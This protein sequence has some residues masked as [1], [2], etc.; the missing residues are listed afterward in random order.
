MQTKKEFV[1]FVL[2]LFIVSILST[3]FII[4]ENTSNIQKEIPQTISFLDRENNTSRWEREVS[5][6]RDPATGQI[7][8]GIR[9]LELKFART[10]PAYN[11]S[12][13]KKN[14]AG[15]VGLDWVSRGPINY[16]GR[17]RALA[18]DVTNENRIIAGGVSGGMWYSTDGG[19]S[20]SKAS[21][22]P[23]YQS[24]SCV[25][26]DTRPGHTNTWYY[27]SGE[28][29]GNTASGGVA[30]LGLGNQGF[31]SGDGIYKSTDSGVTWTQLPSTILDVTS[32]YS[33][34]LVF[35]LAIDPSRMDSTIIYA[36]CFR[37]IYRSNDGGTT[38]SRCNLL[39]TS[40]TDVAVSSKGIVY[41]ALSTNDVNVSNV[42]GIF[43]S[44][45]GLNWTNIS[46]VSFDSDN[47]GRIVI[48]LAPS[49]ENI[50]YFLQGAYFYDNEFLWKYT[51]PGN[52]YGA[53]Q[54]NWDDLSSNLPQNFFTQWSYDIVLKVKPDN[55]KNVIFGG[56]NLYRTT[57]GFATPVGDENWIGGYYHPPSHADMQALAFLPSN[58][59]TLLIGTDGGVYKTI[60]VTAPNVS[61]IVRNNGYI[62]TQFYSVALDHGISGDNTIYGGL[63]DL[64]FLLTHSG[65]PIQPWMEA[66]ADEGGGEGIFLAIA[67]SGSYYYQETFG[68]IDRLKPDNTATSFS[69]LTNITPLGSTSLGI[70]PFILDP[71]NSKVMFLGDKTGI[72]RN[73]DL[74]QIPFG[75]NHSSP[76]SVNWTHLTN[77]NSNNTIKAITESVVPA[78]IVYYAN[79]DGRVFRI[80]SANVGNPVPYDIT[81]SLPLYDQSGRFQ[82]NMAYINCIAVDPDDAANVIIVYTNYHIISLYYSSNATSSSP[83]WIP[84]A[85]NLEENPDGTGN[86]PSCRWAIISKAGGNHSYFVGTSVGLFST[87]NLNGDAT[88]WTKE[89]AD[90]IG[91]SVVKMIDSRRSDGKIIIATHGNG[92]YSSEQVTGISPEVANVPQNFELKQNYPN[93]FNPSTNIDFYL[94]KSGNVRL[95]VY[96]ITGKKVKELLNNQMTSGNH[97]V[98]F[99]ATGL[100]SGVYIYRI[101]AGN[102]AQTKK[103]VLLR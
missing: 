84:V 30:G 8:R 80:D 27:G 99:V 97:T 71:N 40:Y 43:R 75:Y 17:T 44:T 51:Y 65:D 48:G 64:N 59:N 103:M 18:I 69:E 81:G 1:I 98:N 53:E 87:T 78:N 96:D 21:S 70:Q 31:Y 15:T 94:P 85:G 57:D 88:V 7:P 79:L 74:T 11:K 76:T 29:D 37:G 92:T 101:Q 10:L 6:L 86:G 91:S 93:P 63:Q 62:T 90:V 72:W 66:R 32:L 20:W 14:G 4:I 102:F 83:D 24:V 2:S 73:S 3:I 100:A 52:G 22:D 56:T 77:T 54:S 33:F 55:D 82:G 49:N 25:V 50:V 89:G 9:A 42:G 19:D 61:W 35:N 36:A 5:M 13:L 12:S 45:D 47:D 23:E 95:T 34:N 26:Q 67:D 41:A 39:G 16:G 28:Y 68:E 58:S 60:D 38:W 46:P